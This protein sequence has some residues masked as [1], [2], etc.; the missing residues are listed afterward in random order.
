[1][2]KADG[3]KFG[4][5]EGGQ[6]I[7]LDPQRTSPFRFYQFWVNALDADVLNYLRYFTFLT[8]AEVKELAHANQ[9]APEQKA[10]QKR[11]AAEVTRLV[12]GETALERAMRASQVL[13]G[14]SLS[15]VPLEDLLDIFGDAPSSQFDKARFDGEGVA[16]ADVLVESGL[17][18]SKREARDLMTSGGVYVNNARISDANRRLT[19][20]DS[21][22]GQVIVL[23]KGAKAYH[24][25]KLG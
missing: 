9:A 22:A 23:R 21:F 25:V 11:L 3:T 4:K 16:L 7:W 20:A 8:Q 2:T 1:V 10:A 15:D 13:F 19:H 18:K 5:S 12:H 14:G 6:N 17:L 24:L